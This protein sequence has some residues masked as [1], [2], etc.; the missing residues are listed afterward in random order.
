[1]TIELAIEVTKRCNFRCSHCFVDAGAPR[2]D[3]LSTDELRALL[4]D[5]IA[6]GAQRIGWSGGEPTLRKDLVELTGF[7][8]A[9]GVRFGLATNGYGADE[10]RLRALRDN[11]LDV[12]Q[13]SLDGP[14]SE[15][16]SRYRQGPKDGFE[17]AV[18]AVQSGVALGLRTY[19][20]ALLT[21][22]TAGEVVDMISFADSLGATGL[23]YSGWVPVG[24]ATG[25]RY[26]ETQWA[27]SEL[28]DF[29]D[30]V[31]HMRTTRFQVLVDCPTGPHP[32]RDHFRCSV[33]RKSAYITANGDLYPCTALMFPDYRVGNIRDTPVAKLL[34]DSRFFA[35]E[36]QLVGSLPAGE[37]TGCER[38]EQC[39]G[40]C[41]GKTVAAFGSLAGD[42]PR[43]GQPACLWRLHEPR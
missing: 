39:R 7:G 16:A 11:G 41:P 36:Q 19:V 20:A 14:T 18:R 10:E 33:G 24:R 26:D 27:R 28:R 3:E 8:S 9:R 38:A 22:D 21:P 40:G 31:E 43:R 34:F 37:C 1:V 30:A 2:T 5:L 42:G 29:L 23:R 17:R 25:Q 35:V 4:T 15:R 12:V 6:C 32:A 13:V